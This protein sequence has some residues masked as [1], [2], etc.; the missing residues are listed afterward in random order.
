MLEY[1]PC[2]AT[3]LDF[4]IESPRLKLGELCYYGEALEKI[5]T[6]GRSG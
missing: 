5:K 3:G 4:H 1:R 6:F 2:E